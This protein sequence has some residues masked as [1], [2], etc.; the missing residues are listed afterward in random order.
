VCERVMPDLTLDLRHLQYAIT[1]AQ[2]GSFRRAADALNLSQSTVSRRIQMLERRIGMSLFERSRTG[3]CLTHAGERF[4]RDSAFGACHLQRAVTNIGL[5]KRG[6]L[7]EIR[8][9][10][11]ASLASGFLAD[12]FA[13]FHARY[14][15]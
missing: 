2:F 5:I 6:H 4:I 11:T 12:L 1:V 8:V 13:R 15:E 3:A 14:G 9:G 10:M 7:G